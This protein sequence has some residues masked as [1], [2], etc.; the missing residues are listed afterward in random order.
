ML[1][2]PSNCPLSTS[3]DIPA[4]V[5]AVNQT[6]GASEAAVILKCNYM[7]DTLSKVRDETIQININ[8][9][10]GYPRQSAVSVRF[11]TVSKDVTDEN[12]NTTT[13]T[14]DVK[15][16]YILYGNSIKFVEIVPAVQQ[17]QLCHMLR[18]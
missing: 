15:G 4:T 12:G 7:S 2:Y 6:D 14:K 18:S 5:A 13:V 11:Q 10:P 9:Y 3:G 16:V 17:Q 8:T 1:R